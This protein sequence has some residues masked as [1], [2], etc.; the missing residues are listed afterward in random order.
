V[1]GTWSRTLRSVPGASYDP[2]MSISA[3]AR[4]LCAACL[5]A[6]GG[7]APPA[8]Q[9]DDFDDLDDPTAAPAHPLA[10]YEADFILSWNG[11]RVGS[12]H[13]SLRDAGEGLRFVRDEEIVVRR[14]DAELRSSTSI[15]IDIAPWRAGDDLLRATAVHLRQKSAD[16]VRTGEA[17]RESDGTWRVELEGEPARALPAGAVP[18]ELVPFVAAD[19]RRFSGP[20]ILPGWGFASG[21]LEAVPGESDSGRRTLD[22]TL[23][24]DAGV[25]TGQMILAQNGTPTRVVSGDTVSSRADP[26]EAASRFVPPEIVDGTSLPVAGVVAPGA[27]VTLELGPVRRP[28][29]PDLPGQRITAAG[30]TWRVALAPA[31]R[32][33]LDAIAE[34]ARSTASLV[35]DDLGVDITGGAQALAL[36]RGDCTTHA[37][38]FAEL[39]AR[40]GYQ[41]RLV[42]GYRLADGKLTRHRWNI[43]RV[44]ATWYSVDPTFGEGP[45]KPDLIG[46]AV[47]GASAADLALSSEVAF[48]GLSEAQAELR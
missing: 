9:L 45:A 2:A 38:V 11:A 22:L 15:A 5:L 18:A 29:P 34:L 20:V 12:A 40:R 37:V 47:H 46:L 43:V 39:A 48:A 32:G 24:T 30:D 25:L 36:R 41:V 7:H 8:G 42:T 14:G 26:G 13:E 10:G 31:P 6:C 44:G 17:V 35:Q 33:R 21:N 23:T 4:A 27:G 19:G 1:P 28:L 16:I 3:L